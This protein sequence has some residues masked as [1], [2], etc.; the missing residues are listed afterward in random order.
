MRGDK[1][2]RDYFITP[3]VVSTPMGKEPTSIGE[4]LSGIENKG[5]ITFYS[6][7]TLKIDGI[8][9]NI[10]NDYLAFIIDKEECFDKFTF[11]PFSARHFEFK[12]RSIAKYLYGDTRL[13]Y[14]IFIFNDLSHDSDLTYDYLTQ[15][16]LILPNINGIELMKKLNIFKTRVETM[17][18]V[19]SFSQNKF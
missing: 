14:F 13:F 8:N 5:D 2:I 10:L 15:H 1:N 6:F 7:E 4:F 3:R 17:N 16:G 9:H 18:G 19:A 12:S 11:D